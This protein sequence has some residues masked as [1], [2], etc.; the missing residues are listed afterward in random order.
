M[1]SGLVGDVAA[2]RPVRKVADVDAR[3]RRVDE[4]QAAANEGA[5]GHRLVAEL[6]TGEVVNGELRLYRGR[7]LV[8]VDG[9]LE[10][11]VDGVTEPARAAPRAG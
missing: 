9:A 4:E 8:D 1:R 10:A 2:G 5:R 11:H 6:T 3:R 7:G